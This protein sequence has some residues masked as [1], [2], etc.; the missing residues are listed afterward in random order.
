MAISMPTF[1]KSVETWVASVYH[2]TTPVP[3][4]TFFK[5]STPYILSPT[6]W[7]RPVQLITAGGVV[8]VGI[9]VMLYFK[10]R[11]P[12][13]FN[14]TEKPSLEKPTGQTKSLL[15]N[16]RETH[17]LLNPIKLN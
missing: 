9:G 14:K 11:T 10:F 4:Q 6:K 17:H 1:L 2:K 12:E 16:R 3:V 7:S 8:V 13:N 5:N 15:G